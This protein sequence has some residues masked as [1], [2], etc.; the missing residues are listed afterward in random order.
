ML[1]MVA[2]SPVTRV[3][4]LAERSAEYDQQKHDHS[5]PG[6]TLHF[7]DAFRLELLEMPLFGGMAPL[8]V[9]DHAFGQLAE[10]LGRAAIGRTLPVDFMKA[11]TPDLRAYN[12]NRAAEKAGGRKWLVRGY[13]EACRAVLA[14][15]YPT[16]PGNTD[17]LSMI[18]DVLEAE[19]GL[20]ETTL[21]R[22]WVTADAI[23]FKGVFRDV[24]GNGGDYGLGVSIRNG[25]IGQYALEI[26]PLA[27]RHTC[28]NSIV[29]TGGFSTR[30]V[31]RGHWAE[32][33]VQLRAA[34]LRAL[35]GS[36]ETVER[37]FR[38]DEEELPTFASVLDGLCEAYKFDAA[39]KATVWDG[40][41]G[42]MTRAGLVNGVTY[43]AHKA[44]GDDPE[45][46][47][48]IERLGGQLLYAGRDELADYVPA[49]VRREHRAAWDA[50]LAA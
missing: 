5:V 29:S 43:L 35:R 36:A 20:D 12:F 37:M 33:R 42:R 9:T 49:D 32:V 19:P 25:E 31:H 38:A 41:E 28:T 46:M 6:S 2:V 22:P 26:D 21:I 14:G 7:T 8:T 44:F 39:Q 50:Y 16:K 11:L 47:L 15:D 40:T 17:I 13:G 1:T 27:Q 23:M 3:R 4:E 10:K 48:D 18:A 34:I 45:K 24:R 30:I